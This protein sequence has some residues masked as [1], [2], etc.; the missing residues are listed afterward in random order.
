MQGHAIEMTPPKQTA[1][2]SKLEEK[3]AHE[4]EFEVNEQLANIKRVMNEKL[5]EYGVQVYSITITNVHLPDQFRKQME[6]ATTFDSKNK[7]AAAEQKYNLRVIEDNEKRSEATQRMNEAKKELMTDNEMKMAGEVRQTS[8]YEAES[9]AIIADIDEKLNADTL[10]LRTSS[11]LKV[12]QLA[13]AKELIT[14]QLEAEAIAES[15]T[16]LSE[17]EAW[18][19]KTKAEAKAAVA[20]NNALTLQAQAAAEQ[21]ASTKLRH[22]RDFEAK[23]AHLRVLKN[24]AAN[25]KLVLSGTNKDS[26]VAQLLATQQ[27][28]AMVGL[29][30][31]GPQSN[32]VSR[33]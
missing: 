29:N 25:N 33:K 18:V 31:G 9:R 6:D 15:R 19:N 4:G 8:L 11:E 10:D 5:N 23:M 2:F 28:A 24:L 7:K 22:R 32:A 3:E 1:G 26:V 14:A 16:I 27:G 30:V 12:A 13:K 21:V 20:K 17:M